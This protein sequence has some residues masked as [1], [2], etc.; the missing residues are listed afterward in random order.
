MVRAKPR[1]ALRA[2]AAA[3]VAALALGTM[4]PVAAQERRSAGDQALKRAQ[5]MLRLL[6]QEKSELESEVARLEEEKAELVEEVDALEG[7]LASTEAR[8]GDSRQRTQELIERIRSD[9]EKFQSLRQRYLETARELN[10]ANRDNAFLVEAV[11]ERDDW[12]D[13]CRQRNADLFTAGRDVLN[14]YTAVALAETEGIFGF[15]RVT[16]QNEIQE[17]RFRLEDLQVR[18]YAPTRNILP[19]IREAAR[20]GGQA[21]EAKAEARGAASPAS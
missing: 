12:V 8:L 19:F 6:N 17:L 11:Q 13:R 7:E 20:K 3:V 21:T 10:E 4:Q 5:Y 1:I 15:E 9:V 16:I 14:R 18:P 2:L